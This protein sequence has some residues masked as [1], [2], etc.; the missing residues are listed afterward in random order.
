MSRII[1]SILFMAIGMFVIVFARRKKK[2]DREQAEGFV[3][4]FSK[5]GAPDQMEQTEMD[6]FENSKMVSEG[7]QFGVQY[8][9]N[10]MYD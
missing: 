6:D 2:F 10:Q 7:S 5:A 9:N 8:F 4:A 1:M 3:R